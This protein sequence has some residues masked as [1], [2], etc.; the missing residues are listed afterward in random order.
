MTIRERLVSLGYVF[1]DSNTARKRICDELA[2]LKNNGYTIRFPTETQYFQCNGTT[3]T[4]YFISNKIVSYNHIFVYALDDNELEHVKYTT[5]PFYDRIKD[6]I[7]AHQFCTE[8]KQIIDHSNCGQT[9][10][11]L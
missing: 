2:I 1:S 8:Y 5:T 10:V 3:I 9:I 11:D 6:S 7:F 4:C